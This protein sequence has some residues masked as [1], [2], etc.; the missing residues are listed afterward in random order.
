MVWL[1]IISKIKLTGFS[2]VEMMVTLVISISLIMLGVVQLGTYQDQLILN[3]TTK[4]VKSSIEQAARVCTIRHQAIMINY[5]P[6][7]KRIALIGKNYSR[8]IKLDSQI[9][10]YNLTSLKISAKGSISPQTITISNHKS[11][12]KIKLQMMWG[13]VIDGKD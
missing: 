11:S 6:V 4:E 7:S 12:Q 10:V 5:Y 2:L 1:K 8:Q 3:N 13:R 9:E